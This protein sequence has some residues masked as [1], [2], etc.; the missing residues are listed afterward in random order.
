MTTPVP[1]NSF[2]NQKA[3]QMSNSTQ[4]ASKVF[5][6]MYL[7]DGETAVNAVMTVTA[8][9]GAAT[10]SAQALI[11]GFILDTSGSMAEDGGTK[12]KN[13]RN[14]LAAAISLLR[15]TDEFFVIAGASMASVVVAPCLATTANKEKAITLVK[16]IQATGGTVMSSWLKKARE[17]FAASPGKIHQAV[18]LTDG[19]NSDDD[20]SVLPGAIASCEGIFQCECRGVE[21]GFRPEQLRQIADKLL[22]TVDMIRDAAGMTAD[23][24]AIMNK[25]SSLAVNDVSAQVWIPA[26]AKIV[27]FKQMTPDILDLT[28][29]GKPG[30]NAQT[31]RYPT[32]A[33]GGEESRD[34]LVTIE[35]AKAGTV[36]GP[37]Q[38]AGRAAVVFTENGTETKVGEAQIIAMWTDDIEEGSRVEPKVDNYTGQAELTKRVQEGMAARKAGNEEEA[39]KALQRAHQLAVETGN[40]GTRRLIEKVVEVSAKDGTVRLKRNIDEADAVELDTRSS[41]TKRV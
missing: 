23:F 18:L 8:S 19:A 22:G 17:F 12:I 36:G 14:A 16:A 26:G 3:N 27:S 31:M 30:P 41:R 20:R 4:F 40:D 32:G 1:I 5:Q 38:L 2:A 25:S 39:T 34:Y 37:K 9:G 10:A 21:A 29:K 33:W 7:L 15:P 6:K 13:G 35:L 24:T 28:A 11:M